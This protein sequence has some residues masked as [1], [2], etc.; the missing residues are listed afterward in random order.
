MKGSG[1]GEE[2]KKKG[3]KE[4]KEKNIKLMGGMKKI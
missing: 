2:G 1:M 3:E 4:K